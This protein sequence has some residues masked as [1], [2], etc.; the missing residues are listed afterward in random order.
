MYLESQAHHFSMLTMDLTVTSW[1]NVLGLALCSTRLWAFQSAFAFASL[2][3][4]QVYFE[5]TEYAMV[6]LN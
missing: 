1:A 3:W 5:R 6:F 4:H 2:L